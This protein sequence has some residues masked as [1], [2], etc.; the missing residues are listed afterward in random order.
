LAIAFSSATVKPPSRLPE[1]A[2]RRNQT[3]RSKPVAPSNFPFP[4]PSATEAKGKPIFSSVVSSSLAKGNDDD[5]IS[6]S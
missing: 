3:G 4:Q 1:T 5:E 2:L 6:P